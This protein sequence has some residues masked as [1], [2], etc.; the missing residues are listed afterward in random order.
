M[1]LSAEKLAAEAES[2]GFRPE[3]LEK[4]RNCRECSNTLQSNPFL[5]KKLG[6]QRVETRFWNLLRTLISPKAIGGPLG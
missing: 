5:T 2:T 3:A 1:R 6:S 4:V